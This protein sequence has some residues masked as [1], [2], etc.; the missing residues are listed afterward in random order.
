MQAL[1]PLPPRRRARVLVLGLE[2]DPEA[3]G[4]RLQRRLEVQPLG[5]HHEVERVAGLL[6]AE[7]VV[8]LL[9]GPDV[10]R[11][12]ALVVERAEPEVAV[13]PGA[14][15]LGARGD[16]R[17]HVD[18]GEDAVARVGGVAAHGAKATGTLSCSNA[19]MQKRSVIPAR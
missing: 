12:G 17:E 19:R 18:R 10:E 7:A 9:V 13:D 14:A 1:A 11:A 15:Q 6:A 4:Q 8:V 5:L 3:V 2:L 16:E